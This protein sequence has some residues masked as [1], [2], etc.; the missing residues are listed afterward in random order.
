MLTWTSGALDLVLTRLLNVLDLVLIH[1][2]APIPVLAQ[3]FEL[4]HGPK[5]YTNSFLNVGTNPD[6]NSNTLDLDLV[7]AWILVSFP[8]LTPS[9]LNPKSYRSSPSLNLGGPKPT[10]VQTLT[11]ILAR[12]PTI[13]LAWTLRPS[14][15]PNPRCQGPILHLN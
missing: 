6:L 3:C 7:L 15:N 11:L 2:L 4:D 12:S 10:L 5:P 8:N 1:T 9:T 14:S 13:I